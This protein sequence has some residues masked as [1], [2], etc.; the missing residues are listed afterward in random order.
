MFNIAK[1]NLFEQVLNRGGGGVVQ[2]NT[3][4]SDQRS[5]LELRSIQVI[6]GGMF[7]MFFFCFLLLVR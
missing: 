5:I 3:H 2:V 4:A 6:V 7:V 1:S